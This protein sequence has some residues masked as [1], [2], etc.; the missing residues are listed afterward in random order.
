MTE[1]KSS[2]EARNVHFNMKITPEFKAKL[3][4]AAKKKGIDQSGLIRILLSEYF[5]K[6]KI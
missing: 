4:K 1:R 3:E 5:E 6:E 2:R